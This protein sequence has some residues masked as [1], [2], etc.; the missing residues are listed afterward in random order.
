ML[1][2]WG[3]PVAWVVAPLLGAHGLS[4]DVDRARLGSPDKAATSR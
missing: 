1:R 3:A 2:K 4:Q